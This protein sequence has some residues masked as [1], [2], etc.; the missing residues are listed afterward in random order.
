[1]TYVTVTYVQRRPT[2]GG[3]APAGPCTAGAQVS[4]PYAATYTF[5]TAG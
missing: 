4:S 5:Y 1:V 2:K 3:L